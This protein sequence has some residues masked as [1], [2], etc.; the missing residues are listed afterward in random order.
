M[1]I[2]EL[3][4]RIEHRLALV[5]QEILRLQAAADALDEAPTSAVRSARVHGPRSGGHRSPRR[6]PARARPPRRSAAGRKRKSAAL[7]ALA[8]ELDAGLRNRV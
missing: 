6:G 3:T 8:R 4:K 2:A 5:Q 1:T 7:A